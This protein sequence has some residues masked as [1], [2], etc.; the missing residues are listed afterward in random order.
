MKRSSRPRQN[1]A[2]IWLSSVCL[3]GRAWRSS[4]RDRRY[5]EAY[6]V[7]P[8]VLSY[9]SADGKSGQTAEEHETFSTDRPH[10]VGRERKPRGGVTKLG[11]LKTYGPTSEPEAE[12]RAA[13]ADNG[14]CAVTRALGVN[15][16]E[17]QL[18]V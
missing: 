12:L 11:A 3:D 7:R 4:W 5:T 17:Q 16:R 6:V 1:G 2:P 8:Q 14:A 13:R 10:R 18:F 9:R 15:R